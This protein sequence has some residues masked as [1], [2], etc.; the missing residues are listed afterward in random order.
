MRPSVRCEAGSAGGPPGDLYV[1]VRVQDHA[2]FKRDGNNL[3]CEMPISI[4]QAALGTVLD[5]PTLDGGKTRVHV[6]EGTQSGTSFRV[7]GQGVPNL[8]SRG[9]GDLHVSVRVVVPT[10]LSGEQRKLMEQLARTLPVPEPRD[11]ERTF[12]EKLK[13]VMS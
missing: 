11:K 6:P 1:V 12:F 2:F 7:R 3:Y 13:D 5:V 9:K 8:G 4:T 10:R